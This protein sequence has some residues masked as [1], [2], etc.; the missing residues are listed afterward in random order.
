MS[1]AAPSCP[2]YSEDGQSWWDGQQWRPIEPV[3]AAPPAEASHRPQTRFPVKQVGL[4]GAALLAVL[5]GA[6]V[7]LHMS[8]LG[9]EQV[10]APDLL[11]PAQASAEVASW[12]N[13]YTSA[14]KRG[15]VSAVRGMLTGPALE[16]QNAFHTWTGY[17]NDT[18][19]HISVA[20]A[21]QSVYPIW[22]MTEVVVPQTASDGEKGIPINLDMVLMKAS[23]AAPWQDVVWQS[24]LQLPPLRSDGYAEGP[25]ATTDEANLAIRSQEIPAAYASVLT[26]WQSGEL[27]GG[28]FQH[29]YI[30]PMHQSG[31]S[32]VGRFT[33]DP[34]GVIYRS[35]TSDGSE[36]VLFVMD[37]S[38]TIQRTDGRCITS[39]P[40]QSF[41]S[42]ILQL[43]SL[44]RV[45]SAVWQ[46]RLYVQ[47]DIPSQSS[48]AL[49]TG[50]FVGSAVGTQAV[51]C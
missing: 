10:S 28:L 2:I 32:I 45:R 24:G 39:V 13:V 35:G 34:I 40:P 25:L 5:I 17:A 38:Y 19:A 51:A 6:A 3:A 21:H 42:S 9:E 4:G 50:V 12:W 15:D 7:L 31:Y 47:A 33:P 27:T 1:Q 43:Q 8:P 23:S 36:W 49:I 18:L 16:A 48:G 22:F 41:L 44:R 14:A 46:N 37:M 11:T 30:G 20:V 26:G 29:L